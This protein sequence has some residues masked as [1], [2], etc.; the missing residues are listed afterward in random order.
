MVSVGG[1]F[2]SIAALCHQEHF[3]SSS[4]F[5]RN[6]VKCHLLVFKRK[7]GKIATAQHLPS[8]VIGK[9]ANG[10]RC[11]CEVKNPLQFKQSSVPS[12]CIPNTGLS[13]GGMDTGVVIRRLGAKL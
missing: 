1:F 9:D 6:L 12:E 7:D 4:L 8:P 10:A 2:T 13:G 11:I 5:D 3:E